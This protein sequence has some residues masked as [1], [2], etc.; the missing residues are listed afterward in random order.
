M[1]YRVRPII[2]LF[3]STVATIGITILLL[4]IIGINIKHTLFADTTSIDKSSHAS[5][6]KAG[7]DK[8]IRLMPFHLRSKDKFTPSITRCCKLG[9]RIGRKKMTCHVNSYHPEAV[10]G[11]RNMDRLHPLSASSQAVRK[12]MKSVSSKVLSCST[13]KYL[14]NFTKCCEYRERQAREMEACR[15]HG[16]KRERRQCRKEVRRRYP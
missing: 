2:R 8:K 9:E 6:K 13:S 10:S 12:L 3:Y 15:G 7:T 14:G 11:P 16:R 5:R 1:A 4:Q